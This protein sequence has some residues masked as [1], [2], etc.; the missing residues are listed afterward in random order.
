M[1]IY[2]GNNNLHQKILFSEGCK[3]HVACLFDFMQ[4][5]YEII[6]FK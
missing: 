2:D 3:M 4:Q 5:K 6:S 1:T